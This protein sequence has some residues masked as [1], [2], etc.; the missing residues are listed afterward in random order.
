MRSCDNKNQPTKNVLG[1]ANNQKRKRASVSC[2]P[3]LEN[4]DGKSVIPN[5]SDDIKN[6]TERMVNWIG[7]KEKFDATHV[8][9]RLEGKEL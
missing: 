3:F 6:L 9:A 1:N 7:K 5:S 8:A 4:H 2:T